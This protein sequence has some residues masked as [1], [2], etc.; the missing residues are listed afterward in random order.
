MAD[1]FV[2]RS[3]GCEMA[4]CRK[5]GRHYEPMDNT[6]ECDECQINAAIS[7]TEQITKNFGGN[8]E[9]AARFYGW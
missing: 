1:K 2:C 4:H 8:Y 5:C 3:D 9:E 6:G 7:E